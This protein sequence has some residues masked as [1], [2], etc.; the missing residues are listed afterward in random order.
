M[1]RKVF[2]ILLVTI[3]L[4]NGAGFY[5][6]FCFR[7]VEI[8]KEM[9]EEIAR[10]SPELFQKI[11]LTKIEYIKLKVGDHELEWNGSMYD[12]AHIRFIGDR[13]EILALQDGLETELLAFASG[14]VQS[15]TGDSKTPPSSL[16]QYLSLT[17]TVPNP[18]FDLN[19]QFYSNI[20][21]STVYTVRFSTGYTKIVAPPPRS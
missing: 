19:S 9:Q 21:H 7:L 3:I 10:T 14:I 16:L 4:V 5:I 8:K 6:Y 1:L 11:S 20:V 17:F 13:V 18:P 2:S 15:A 12:V